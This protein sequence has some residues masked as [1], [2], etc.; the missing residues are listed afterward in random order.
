MVYFLQFYAVRFLVFFLNM[1]PLAF[2]GWIA[3]SIG[4]AFYFISGKRRKIALSNVE[5][6][7]GSTL[8]SQEKKTLI[9][10]SFQNT[11]LSILE[12]FLI[13]K[14][15]KDAEK[16]F[17]IKGRENI[18]DALAQG[19]G[20]IL[21]TTH[22]GS[23]EY[24]EFLFYLT[25]IKCSVIVKKIKNERLD[26]EINDLRRETTVTPIPKKHAIR[27]ALSELKKNNVLAVLIDQWAGKEG[28]WGSFFG[29][30]TSTTSLPARLA[31]K[32]GCLLVP[33]YCLRTSSGQYEIQGL[34][35]VDLPTDETV[36]WE[37]DVTNRLNKILETNIRKYPEQWSWTHRRW[38]DK[39]DTLR[40]T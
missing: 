8:S 32:T 20:V 21:I 12:L 2:S 18:D 9:K 35:R 22:L 28:L 17:I 26:K 1:L 37:T 36:D 40:H 33:A 31:K 7:Y 23:W 38:K 11:A 13:K 19:K 16:H 10:K 30:F 14:I 24:L 6:A 3:K 27:E 34:P 25:G 15:K 4:W 29:V 5:K 39:P